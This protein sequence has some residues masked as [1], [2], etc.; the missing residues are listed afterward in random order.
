MKTTVMSGEEA[1]KFIDKWYEHGEE[2]VRIRREGEKVIVL[3][4]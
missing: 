1:Q 4:E 2:N 3:T